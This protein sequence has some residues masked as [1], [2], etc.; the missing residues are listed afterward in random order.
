MNF[1]TQQLYSGYSGSYACM[2][3]MGTGETKRRLTSG[4]WLCLAVKK[5][6]RLVLR[7]WVQQQLTATASWLCDPELKQKMAPAEAGSCE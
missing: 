6:L 1:S 4:A 3:A 7:G 5:G 2:A